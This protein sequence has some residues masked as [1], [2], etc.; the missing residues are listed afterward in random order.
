MHVEIDDR[1]A[2]DA[3]RL[4]HADCDRDIVERAEAFAVV[5]EGVMKAAADVGRYA[6]V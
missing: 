5:R 1:D 6:E 2:V 4:Q 3:P